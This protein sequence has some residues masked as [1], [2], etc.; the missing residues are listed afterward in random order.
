MI[1]GSLTSI[2]KGHG[3]ISGSD[4]IHNSPTTIQLLGQFNTSTCFNGIDY[5]IKLHAVFIK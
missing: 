2:I 3:H 4:Y 1:L 5:L